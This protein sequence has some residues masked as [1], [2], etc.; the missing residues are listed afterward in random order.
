MALYHT[1]FLRV[2]NIQATALHDAESSGSKVTDMERL[3]FPG[4]YFSSEHP[5]LGLC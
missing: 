4:G 2:A 3:K 5:P 1:N